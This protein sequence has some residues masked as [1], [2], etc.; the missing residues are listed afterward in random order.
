MNIVKIG[1]QRIGIAAVATIAQA[2]AE[3]VQK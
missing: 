1:F 3:L 2:T